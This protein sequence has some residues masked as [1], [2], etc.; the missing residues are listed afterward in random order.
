MFYSLCYYWRI[1]RGYRLRPWRSP[2]LAWR[3]ETF[4][5]GAAA[6]SDSAKGFFLLLWRH[7]ARLRSF[8]RW[9][10]EFERRYLRS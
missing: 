5:G 2:Y 7:R 6:S 3:L 8:L 9:A 1:S 4:F 10:A